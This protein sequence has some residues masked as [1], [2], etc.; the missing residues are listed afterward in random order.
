MKLS[1]VTWN[2]EG[3]LYCGK[4]YELE[5]W[6]KGKLPYL[7]TNYPN[8]DIYAIQECSQKWADNFYEGRKCDTFYRDNID[9]GER[10]I[11]LFSDRFYIQRLNTKDELYRYVVPYVVMDK[12]TNFKFILIHVWT[13]ELDIDKNRYHGYVE[14]VKNALVDKEYIEK[15][16]NENANI[17][18]IGDFNFGWIYPRDEKTANIFYSEIGKTFSLKPI[19]RLSKDSDTFAGQYLNDCCFCTENWIIKDSFKYGD[20]AESDHRPVLFNLELKEL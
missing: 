11:A 8:A 13:K 15:I 6:M 16:K 18:C 10:G 5:R 9:K 20:Y 14:Q 3:P 12:A 19:N 4:D 7:K 2:C 17:V 1:L